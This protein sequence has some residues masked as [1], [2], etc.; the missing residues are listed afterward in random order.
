MT[1]GGATNTS[2]IGRL[3]EE[4]SWEG[5]RVVQLYR[6]GGRGKENVLTAEVMISL[7]FMP[8]THFLGAVLRAAHGAKSALGG[9]A[10]Q[11]EDCE[12]SVLPPELSLLPAGIVVQPDALLKTPNGYVLVEAKGL[13]RASFGPQQLAREY[14]AVTRAAGSRD[15][16]LLLILGSPPPFTVRG[17]GPKDIK[18]AISESLSLVLH[19]TGAEGELSDDLLKRIP[20]V[21]S[22]ITWAEINTVVTRQLSRMKIEDPSL[23]GTVKRL[24]TAVSAAIAVHA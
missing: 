18:Q 17:Q 22:W 12:I 19:K 14:L 3:L 13:R 16:V 1:D 8:R 21:V 20:K 9:V 4:I 24:A 15:P 11:I 10:A 23:R 2:I 5:K 6:G 7:D